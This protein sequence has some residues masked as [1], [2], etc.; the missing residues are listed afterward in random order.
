MTIGLKIFLIVFILS[1]PFWW[2]INFFQKD[3]EDFLFWKEMADNPRLLTAQ[4][5][6]EERL[7]KLK[8]IRNWQVEDLEIEAK[9]A[10][11]VLI[12]LE[13]KERILFEKEGDKKLPIASLTKLMT[14][15]VAME[16]YDLSQT[17]EIGKEAAKEKESFGKLRVGEFFEVKDLLFSLLIESSNG[18]A[19]A[20]A[21]IIGLENF[22]DLM[23]LRAENLSLKNTLFFNP[24]GLDSEGS[25]NRVNYSTVKDLVKLTLY[26]LETKP[27]IWEILSIYEI[28]LYSP[29]GVFHHKIKNTNEIL[30]EIPKIIGGK[31]GWTP[32][33]KG[34]LILIIEAPKNKGKIINI[35]LGSEN[36]FEEMRKLTNWLN[37]AYRW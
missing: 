7:E 37:S 30:G 33:A 12:D 32:E 34:C 8:P 25:I 31:T 23:N 10:I 11:S 13:N 5:I 35:I 21:E 29:N 24:T 6:Q 20:L 18:A 28:D 1:L 2:G 4:M 36:R 17:V 22:V 27:M 19:V 14:A 15:I 26:V 3:F 9:S 16:N